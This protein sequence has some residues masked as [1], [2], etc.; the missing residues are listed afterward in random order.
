MK[1]G[2]ASPRLLGL[3]K[4]P[5]DRSS[6]N[7]FALSTPIESRSQAAGKTIGGTKIPAIYQDERYGTSFSYK[8]PVSNGLYQ[9]QLDF[10]EI[11]SGCSTTGCRVFNVSVNGVPWLTNFDISNRVGPYTAL[12]ESETVKVTNGYI[13]ISMSG[14]TAQIAGIEVTAATGQ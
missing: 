5:T 7:R 3:R 12:T 10:A 14:K 9:L 4:R 6:R 2:L 11:Y 13:T 8:L 1:A